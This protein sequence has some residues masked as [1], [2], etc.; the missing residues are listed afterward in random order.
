MVTHSGAETSRFGRDLDG[1]SWHRKKNS[2]G[3]CAV[4]DLS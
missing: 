3:L 4:E 2:M 1:L